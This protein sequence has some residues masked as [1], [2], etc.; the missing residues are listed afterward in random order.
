M[1]S[2]DISQIL[3]PRPR[4]YRNL[5][6]HLS[7]YLFTRDSAEIPLTSDDIFMDLSSSRG[8]NRFL[9]HFSIRGIELGLKV[10]GVN[11]ILDKAGLKA[12]HVILNTGEPF[13]HR[14]SLEHDLNRRKVISAEINIRRAPITLPDTRKTPTDCLIVEWF[15]L[16]N[17]LKPFSRNHPQL[18]GQDYPGLGISALVFEMLYWSARRLQIDGVMFIPNYLHTGVFYGRQCGFLD[19]VRQGELSTIVNTLLAKNTLAK[20]SWACAEGQLLYQVTNKPYLWNPAPMVLP[21]SRKMKDWFFSASYTTRMH[22][23]R[24]D[25]ALKISK[26]YTKQFDTDWKAMSDG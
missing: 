25:F 7:P 4:K 1:L 13:L 26:S 8:T 5:I 17:P 6:R 16:Q 21:V 15:L 20:T 12:G 24:N 11:E 9:G 22:Q 19:P 3:K 18:P 23:T 10:F 14:I 2:G